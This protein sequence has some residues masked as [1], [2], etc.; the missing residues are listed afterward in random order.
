[1][2]AKLAES[3]PDGAQ[4]SKAK[5]MLV[6]AAMEQLIERNAEL[7]RELAARTNGKRHC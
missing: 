7:E 2:K 1:L 3:T 4:I 6:I 5:L